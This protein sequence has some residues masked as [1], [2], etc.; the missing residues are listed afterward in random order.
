MQRYYVRVSSFF[1]QYLVKAS[2]LKLISGYI[3]PVAIALITMPGCTGS[4]YRSD[5]AGNEKNEVV[6]MWSDQFDYMM[7]RE[8]GFPGIDRIL[9]SYE[10]TIKRHANRYGF[11]WQLILAVMYQESGFQT[12]AVSPKGAYGLMQIMPAT[13]RDIIT[14]L[15]I[16]NVIKP[17][18]NI[19]A[20]IYYLWWLYSMFNPDDA[21]VYTGATQ[22]DRLR[23]ALA[24]YNGGP[25][26]VRDAQ[27]LARYLELD[28]YRWEIVKPLLTMLTDRYSTLHQYVWNDGIPSGGYFNGWDETI[29]YVDSVMEY[30]A[31]Y[32]YIFE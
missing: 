22:E 31:Y 17:E 25:T 13:G 26:R 15:L 20:G 32:L 29:P 5:E 27:Q 21:D 11:D 30:Y 24:A 28:P 8:L 12:R 6:P 10:R 7:Q 16:D 23:L 14:T 4:N 18:N 19:T 9:D 1:P 3:L 2:P